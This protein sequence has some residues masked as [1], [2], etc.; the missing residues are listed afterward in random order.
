MKLGEI[1]DRDWE[2]LQAKLGGH[3]LQSAPWARFQAAI[4]RELAGRIELSGG[5]AQVFALQEAGIKYLWAPYGPTVSTKD[6]T[7]LLDRETWKA[8][9]ADFIRFEPMGQIREPELLRA[10]AVPSVE[11]NPAHT[12]ILDLSKS[13]EELRQGLS[14]GHRNAINGAERR[15]LSF[16]E[17]STADIDNLL[18][19]IHQTGH[20]KRFRPHPDNYYR[21]MMTVLGEAGVAKTFVAKHDGQTVAVAVAFDYNGTRIY[22]HAAADP[23]A[24][25]LQPAVPLVWH[26]LLEAKRAGLKKLD[27]WGVAPPDAPPNHPWTGFSQFKRAFGGQ[28]VTYLGT[29][30]LPLKGWRYRI[31]RG[32]RRAN[33]WVRR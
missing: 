6:G 27:L 16:E 9:G 15:G 26:M 24:K 30:D 25:R 13:E 32:A 28:E 12:V 3:L 1:D 8:T 29:W 19:F 11:L 22:A 33:R 17:G 31:Y 23:T 21:Q 10:G 18:R 7:K 20:R 2:R 14:S 5:S 4:G